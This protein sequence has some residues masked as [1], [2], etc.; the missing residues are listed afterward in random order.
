M[1][2]KTSKKRGKKSLPKT[3]SIPASATPAEVVSLVPSTSISMPD[4]GSL[5]REAEQEPDFRVLSTYV[6]S[7]RMLRK[8]R[9]SYREIADWLSERGVHV[10][11]NAV[12]RVYINSLSYYDAHL[13]GL[14]EA[15]EEARRNS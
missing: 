5:F 11:H 9:F 8:K 10:D 3:A 13:E 14:R 7:I 4:P 12:Y 6:D 15:E 1:K 2:K